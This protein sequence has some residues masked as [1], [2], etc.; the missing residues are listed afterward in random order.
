LQRL[1]E[2]GAIALI[3]LGRLKVP[4]HLDAIRLQLYIE[5]NRVDVCLTPLAYN[6]IDVDDAGPI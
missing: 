1:A 6:T 5:V 3:P 4:V 2:D